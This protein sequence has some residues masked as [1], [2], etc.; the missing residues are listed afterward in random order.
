M[1]S[2][3][4]GAGHDGGQSNPG[5]SRRHRDSLAVTVHLIPR[6]WHLLQLGC[7]SSHFTLPFLHSR[8]P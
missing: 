5:F 7:A 1:R 4:D 6:R 2:E 8:H 3:Q